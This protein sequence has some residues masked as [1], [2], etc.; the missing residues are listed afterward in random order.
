M[1]ERST[2]ASSWLPVIAY[3]AA[4]IPLYLFPHQVTA[5]LDIQRST[6]L[7]A[8]L[9]AMIEDTAL[10]A[11]NILMVLVPAPLRMSLTIGA[12]IVAAFAELSTIHAMPFDLLM[13]VRAL[14]GA[15]FGVAGFTAAQFIAVSPSPAR[16]FGMANGILA[17]TSGL[18]LA[19]VPY[20][21]GDTAQRVF[22]PLAIIALCLAPILSR[23]AKFQRGRLQSAGTAPASS[24]S[25]WFTLPVAGMF[26]IASLLF[27]PLGGLYVF[28]GYQGSHL[29]MT[30]SAIGIALGWT[31][32]TGLAG[33]SGAS[34]LCAK[35]GLFYPIVLT[36]LLAA[37]TCFAIG[38]VSTPTLFILAFALFGITY[39]FAMTAI[40]TI[41]AAADLTGRAAAVLVGWQVLA[42][43]LGSALVGYLIEGH[44]AAMIWQL[45]TIACLAALIPAVASAKAFSN[46]GQLRASGRT[47]FFAE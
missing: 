19:L 25:R 31:T 33:G 13:A 46:T 22:A 9:L 20:L 35:L 1:K 26:M 42:V 3:A 16:A 36:C 14:A 29:H 34:W 24:S 6:T 4:Y 44:H 18:L 17:L 38:S 30:D 47:T 15:G 23:A 5:Y 43:A 7:D 45:G 28:A 37:G 40:S 21:P 2:P 27:I 8:G 39:M 11:A 10:A 41:C 32:V 12:S